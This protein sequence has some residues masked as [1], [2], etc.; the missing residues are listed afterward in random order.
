MNKLTAIILAGGKGSRMAPWPAPKCLMPVAGVPILHWIYRNLVS[1][2]D[3]Y[4]RIIVCVGYRAGD[5]M[6]G[7]S[8]LDVSFSNAGEDAFMSERILRAV[9]D[10]KVSGPILVL[11]GDEISDVHAVKLAIFHE[12]AVRNAGSSM[13]ITVFKEELPFGIMKG[14]KIAE[15]EEV[16]INI[17]Y[18]I[19]EPEALKYAETAYGLSDIFNA[20]EAS[21]VYIHKGKRVTINSIS[22][23]TKA[24]EIWR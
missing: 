21:S 3:L 24:E 16:F 19:I 7:A 17:G 20:C 15:G 12:E 23:V 5:V 18:A 22:D 13:T 6:A 11:Y 4:E 2:G 14:T 10:Y 8:G 1:R 9:E